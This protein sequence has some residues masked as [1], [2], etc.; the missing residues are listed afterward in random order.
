MDFLLGC[1]VDGCGVLLWSLLDVRVLDRGSLFGYSGANVHWR[2]GDLEP[3]VDVVVL[4][5]LVLFQQG[6]E[7]ESEG[8]LY[9]RSRVVSVE[10]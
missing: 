9:S 5:D 8:L 1:D 4:V 7:L 2:D 6:F 3:V 10:V